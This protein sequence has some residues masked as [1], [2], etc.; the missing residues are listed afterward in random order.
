MKSISPQVLWSVVEVVIPDLG[1]GRIL[2]RGFRACVGTAVESG[3]AC[4]VHQEIDI[5]CFFC[6]DV[7]GMLDVIVGCGAALDWDDVAVD[8]EEL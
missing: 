5:S 2:R 6:D 8:L 7:D 4:V 3:L 1:D